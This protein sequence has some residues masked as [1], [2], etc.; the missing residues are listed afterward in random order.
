MSGPKPD[1][2]P[3]GDAP[4]TQKYGVFPPLC[5]DLSIWPHFTCISDGKEVHSYY[6]QNTNK[7]FLQLFPI[8]LYRI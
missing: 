2:L 8:A 7:L 5:Q 4:F 3:L 1:A 6:V